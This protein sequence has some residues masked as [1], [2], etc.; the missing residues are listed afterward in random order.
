M[1]TIDH[2]GQ[3]YSL[4]QTFSWRRAMARH[5]EV[6]SDPLVTPDPFGEG[7]ALIVSWE[8]EAQ[9]LAV[10]RGDVWDLVGDAE[11]SEVDAESMRTNAGALVEALWPREEGRTA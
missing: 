3:L 7:L 10:P 5:L 6:F 8:G 4:L 2:M 11:V 1:K 9:L